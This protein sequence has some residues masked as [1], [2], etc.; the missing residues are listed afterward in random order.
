MNVFVRRYSSRGTALDGVGG[1]RER[2]AAETNQRHAAFEL[3]AQDPDRLE[4][5]R[6]GFARLELAK[7]VD[8]GR[9]ANRL[10]DRRSLALHEIEREAHWLERHEQ[11]GEKDCGVDVDG[12][13]RLEG[14]LDGERGLAAQLEQG[15]FRPESPVL[16]HVAPRLT[17]EPDGRRV[18]RLAP[19]RAEEPIVH[20]GLTK[21]SSAPA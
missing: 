8:V 9:G 14:H 21:P 7:P 11:V 5:V 3:A 15:I 19:A 4:D 1:K 17:H 16:G 6:Q 10:L 2:R 18:H 20:G 12:L 13:D